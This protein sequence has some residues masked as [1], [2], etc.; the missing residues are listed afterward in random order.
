VPIAA[1]FLL[2]F[3]S[4]NVSTLGLQRIW[5]TAIGALV[6]VLVSSLLWPPDPVRELTR[7]LDRLRHELVL[8]LTAVADDLATGRG[9]MSERLE[10]VRAHSLDAVRDVFALDAARRALRWSPLRRRDAS[11]VDELGERINLAARAYRHTRAVARDVADERLHEPRL[12]AA[13]RDLADALDRS[14][15]R[16]DPAEPLRRAADRLD[17]VSSGDAVVVAAQLRQLHSDLADRSMRQ[18]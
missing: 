14:L 10:D 11:L 2:G 18:A 15:T 5:E 12:A 4:A 3:A 17:A 7:Q 1:L 8:D 6:A 16:A 13:V 9:G